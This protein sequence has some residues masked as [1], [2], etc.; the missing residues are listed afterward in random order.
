MS[1]EFFQTRMGQTYYEHTLPS[2]VEAIKAQ[3]E[4]LKANTEAL[5]EAN[6]TAMLAR[7]PKSYT[8]KER[9]DP[10]GACAHYKCKADADM[11]GGSFCFL[12]MAY[13]CG[14][15][16]HCDDFDKRKPA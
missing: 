3:A 14:T 15:W 4:A 5:K 8:E 6:H 1:V 7:L 11:P 12:H 13:V 2:L 10:C 9:P 16:G